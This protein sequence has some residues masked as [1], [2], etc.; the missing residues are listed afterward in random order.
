MRI[1]VTGGSGF[2][3]RHLLPLLGGQEVVAL[4][5][6]KHAARPF[7]NVQW[8]P[9]DLS[10][11]LDVTALPARCDAIIHLAQSDQYR[12]FPGGAADMF[13]VNVEV[14]A[15]LMRWAVDAGV[16]RAVF[17][18]SGTV[19][20]P[21]TGALAETASVN[22]TGYYGAS[23]LAAETLTLAY[24]SKLAVAQLRVFFLY[25]PGQ[26]NMMISRL[27]DNVRSGVA[28]TLPREGEGVRFVPTYVDDTAQIF[29][30]A[31]LEQWRG[32]WNVASPHPVSF[33]EL[34]TVVGEAVGRVPVFNRSDAVTPQPIVPDLTKITTRFEV[35]KFLDVQ[36][37]II[38]TL[39]AVR[40]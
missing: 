38:R 19:Y 16:T 12:T 30:K 8:L 15:A 17:A 36:Q 7:A 24:Q 27:I 23:K 4:T 31:C 3:G 18:S 14:P 11:G 35:A 2:L 10:R 37:G 22:P 34:A 9:M 26:T 40:T 29:A 13:R 25:G 33:K 5:R 21:F 39:A 1:L 28:L 6:G 20:E 32:I